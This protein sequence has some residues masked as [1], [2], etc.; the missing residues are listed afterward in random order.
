MSINA[1]NAPTDSDAPGL[2]LRLPP[3]QVTAGQS[4]VQGGTVYRYLHVPGHGWAY[5]PVGPAPGNPNPPAQ[6]PPP[7]AAHLP[8]HPLIT[9]PATVTGTLSP[10]TP[11]G[12]AVPP[13]TTPPF[14]STLG[15]HYNSAPGQQPANLPAPPTCPP[16]PNGSIQHASSFTVTEDQPLDEF[17][18]DPQ[19]ETV[20]SIPALPPSRYSGSSKGR[21]VKPALP[22]PVPTPP[23]APPSLLY[24]IPVEGKPS[25][26]AII[27][28]LLLVEGR[29]SDSDH[30]QQEL[31][32]Q[33]QWLHTQHIAIQKSIEDEQQRAMERIKS[34]AEQVLGSLEAVGGTGV[35]S[36]AKAVQD[37][38]ARTSKEAAENAVISTIVNDVFNDFL[39]VTKM[40]KKEYLP[41]IDDSDPSFWDTIPYILTDETSTIRQER[42]YWKQ[43]VKESKHNHD[44][45]MRLVSHARKF[46]NTYVQGSDQLVRLISAKDLKAKFVTKFDYLRKIWR[47][48]GSRESTAA[49][50]KQGSQKM[51]NRAKGK[52]EARLRKFEALP[53]SDPFKTPGYAQALHQ[54][55]MSDDEDTF[56]PDGSLDNKTYTSCAAVWESQMLREFKE[57]VDTQA[58]PLSGNRKQPTERK[59]SEIKKDKK[60]HKSQTFDGRVRRW[61]IDETWWKEEGKALYDSPLYVAENGKA[62]G[63]EDDPEEIAAKAKALGEEKKR[64]RVGDGKGQGKTKKRK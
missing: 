23:P 34:Y 2:A 56:N 21:T 62:W 45:L 5:V 57:H 41:T 12:P 39:G 22:F 43:T 40:S 50:G 47:D 25:P 42:F 6:Y 18:L 10:F 17:S 20:A 19:L 46:S 38:E 49:G 30:R 1:G 63:E 37:E 7:P 31:V 27:R 54:S 29:I 11:L 60:I 33:V 26:E 16:T 8:A 32:H 52:Y 3:A 58:D 53:A 59:R 15:Q 61:M 14:N 55:L 36:D 35:V 48:S 28:E 24:S 44:A 4:F 13:P 51:K 9:P 64:K